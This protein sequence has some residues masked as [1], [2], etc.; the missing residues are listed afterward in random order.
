MTSKSERDQSQILYWVDN[1]ERQSTSEPH[2]KI[3]EDDMEVAAALFDD[4]SYVT[5]NVLVDFIVSG[6][7]W[8]CKREAWDW[9]QL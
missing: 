7:V 8:K 2:E 6:R 5:I 9:L 1:F 4:D 3:D